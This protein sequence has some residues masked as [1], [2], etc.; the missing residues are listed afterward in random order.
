M[1]L[2][3][4]DS[5]GGWNLHSAPVLLWGLLRDSI[6]VPP[7][8]VNWKT[9]PPMVHLGPSHTQR[10]HKVTQGCGVRMG[11]RMGN[12]FQVPAFRTCGQERALRTGRGERGGAGDGR[13]W[14][15]RG[16]RRSSRV[17]RPTCDCHKDCA[18]TQHRA[19]PSA[20]VVRLKAALP[21]LP[22]LSALS[23][24]WGAR[25]TPTEAAL[26]ASR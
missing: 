18:R 19:H 23:C 2:W 10:S 16:P 17:P 25:V 20:A 8:L 26:R 4:K 11:P 24:R 22:T 21:R 13:L 5:G 3:H 1:P 14:G 12:C 15:C 7:T 6:D 9:A